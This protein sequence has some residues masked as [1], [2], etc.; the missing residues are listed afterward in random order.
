MLSKG[1]ETLQ[2]AWS[3]HGIG[4]F[5]EVVDYLPNQ[6]GYLVRCYYGS[7]C[8]NSKQFSRVLD[9]VI[10]DAQALGIDT[11]TPEEINNMLSLWEQ[12]RKRN[13]G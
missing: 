11:R 6:T 12:E 13:A 2:K 8:Y 4:W 7:S 9:A 10:Q 3:M 1:A 5:T